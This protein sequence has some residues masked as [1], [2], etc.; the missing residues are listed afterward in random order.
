MICRR[1]LGPALALTLAAATPVSAQVSL[2]ADLA[3]LDPVTERPMRPGDGEKVRLQVRLTEPATGAT[4]RGLYLWAWARPVTQGDADCA[5]AAQN[6]R[7]TR[8]TPVG[9]VSLNGVIFT[10]LNRDASLSV[11]DP[12]LNLYSSNMLSAHVFNAA[13]AAMAMDPGRMRALLAHTTGDIIEADLAGPSRRT[14]A[15][16]LGPLA[17]I[18]VARE[19]DIWL[20]T[21]DGRLVRLAPDGTEISQSVFGSGEVQLER[22]LDPDN[23]LL[24]VHESDGNARLLDADTGTDRVTTRFPAPLVDVAAMQDVGILGLSAGSSSLQIRYADAPDQPFDVPLGAQFTRVDTG[25][26]GRVAVVWTPADSLVALVDLAEGRV[27][28]QVSLSGAG[29]TEV[30]FT[31]NAA[32][33]LSHDGGFVGVLDLAT[34]ALGQSAILRQV[35]L[36]LNADIPPPEGRLLLPLLPSPQVLAVSPESQTGWLIGE[37]ASSVEMP[38]MESLRLRGGIPADVHAVD[39]S[40]REVE[41]GVYEAAWAFPAGEWELVMTTDVGNL[42]TCIPFRVEGE[43]ERRQLVPVRLSTTQGLSL[44]A[45][46][47]QDVAFR[48]L[49]GDGQPVPLARLELMVPS[50]TSSWSTRVSAVADAKGVFT[51]RVSVPHAGPFALHPLNLPEPYRVVSATIVTATKGLSP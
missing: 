28:Q 14:L 48:V 3:L 23:P 20:G 17:D 33:L 13:P 8:Q 9:S 44:I 24:L 30:A 1:I 6:F 46:R 39:R 32:W 47:P 42:S 38:P 21:A 49:D 50:M 7:A 35:R 5:R 29:V 4:P 11:V 40:F 18:E 2:Q 51:A 27:V 22:P 34:V 37:L 25:P 19:G 41:P 26:E 12:R 15:T 45:G 31:D 36:G 43:V 16:G 10:T